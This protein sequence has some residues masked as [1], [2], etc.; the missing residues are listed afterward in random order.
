MKYTDRV[1]QAIKQIRK[2][3]NCTNEMYSPART[4]EYWIAVQKAE[5][6]FDV[7]GVKLD[8]IIQCLNK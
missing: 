2:Q 1:E 7:S 8:L 5:K 6:E 4:Q 3:L